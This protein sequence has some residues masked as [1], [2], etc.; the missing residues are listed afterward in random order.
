MIDQVE[1][2]DKRARVAYLMLRAI[3]RHERK[4]A[5]KKVGRITKKVGEVS[6]R[7]LQRQR[8]KL[9]VDGRC[10]PLSAEHRAKLSAAKR[11]NKNAAGTRSPEHRAKIAAALRGNKNCLGH[12]KT[13]EAKANHSAAMARPETRARLSLAHKGKPWSPARWAAQERRR[14]KRNEAQGTDGSD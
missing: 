11:G 5:T 10:R 7:T 3:A 9:G 8:Q 12:K 13:P 4:R 14:E 2:D 1:L 6:P